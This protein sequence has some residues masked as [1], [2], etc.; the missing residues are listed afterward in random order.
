MDW[1]VSDF[2]EATKY[3]KVPPKP[4][5]YIAFLGDKQFKSSGQKTVFKSIGVLKQSLRYCLDY[6]VKEVVRKK[7]IGMGVSGSDIHRHPWYEKAYENFFDQAL[8][9][10]YLR[11]VELKANS[12]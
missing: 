12:K 10:G 4:E 11:I 5:G 1:T 6:S 2:N 9:S 3:Y 8:K 7:L